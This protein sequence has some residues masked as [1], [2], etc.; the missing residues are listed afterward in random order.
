MLKKNPENIIKG[1]KSGAERAK[2]A[3]AFGAAADKK[4]PFLNKINK[5]ALKQNIIRTWTTWFYV[6]FFNIN[7]VLSIILSSLSDVL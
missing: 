4:E 7:S 6:K 2:A 5:Y 1:T 3:F